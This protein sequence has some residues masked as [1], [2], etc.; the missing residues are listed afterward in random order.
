M[1]SRQHG[2]DAGG[3]QLVFC[4]EMVNIIAHLGHGGVLR[5]A[6]VELGQLS[7]GCNM[8]CAGWKTATNILYPRT[9]INSQRSKCLNAGKLGNLAS[10][11]LG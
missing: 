4:D 2:V 5:G 3:R 9:N 8:T 6:T 10:G 1:D 11:S 7:N